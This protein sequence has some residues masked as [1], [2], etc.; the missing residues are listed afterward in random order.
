MY[1]AKQHGGGR[2]AVAH[3]DGAVSLH[4]RLA[5]PPA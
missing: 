4:L 2:F 5:E 3:G 1:H